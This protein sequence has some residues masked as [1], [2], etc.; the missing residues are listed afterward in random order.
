MKKNLIVLQEGYKECGAASLLSIIR[1]Y[2]GNVSMTR[3]IELTQTNQEGT[4]FYYLKKAAEEIGLEA[5][6]YEVENIQSLKKIKRPFI[7]QF[8]S[9]KC[10]HFVVVFEIKKDKIILMDPAVGE[11]TLSIKEFQS[12]WTS[13]IMI[14]SPAKQ[15][16]FYKEEKY[17]NKIIVE[18]IRKNKAIVLDILLLSIIFMITSFACTTY[19]EF[20]LDYVLDTNL[21]NLLVITLIFSILLLIKSTTSYFRNKLLIYLNQKN[22]CSVLLNTFQ[23]LLLLPY[24]YYKNRTTGEMISRVNDLIYVKNIL[25]KIILTVFLDCIIFICFSIILWL[26]NPRMFLLLVLIILINIIIFNLFRPKLKKNIE[27][28]QINS[29]ILNSNLVE[30]ISGFETIKNMHLEGIINQQIE[31]IYIKALNDN[32]QY[33]DISNLELYIKDMISLIGTLII[34]FLGFVMVMKNQMSIGSFLTFTFLA[35]YVLEPVENILNLNKEYFYAMN[36]IKRANHLFEV[37]SEKFDKKTNFSLKGNIR[38][39]HLTFCYR[40]EQNVLKD[41]TILIPKGEKTIILGNSG[42]GKSTIY[43]LLLKYYPIKRDSIY[44]DEIDLND[45]SIA[46][47]REQIACMSQNEIIFNDTIKNNIIVNRNVSDEEFQKIVKIT[48]VD[49]FVKELFLGYETKLEENGLNLSGGQRQRI[50]LARMLL[51]AN[52]IMLIDEGLNAVDIN[53]ER[54]ILK[55]IFNEYSKNTI[56][57]ISHR[58]DNLDLF[59]HMICFENGKIKEER[60]LPKEKLYD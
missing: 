41:I 50:I 57:V 52:K 13:N 11:K 1:Y 33:E 29:A 2:R 40:E 26:K 20:I 55:N 6:G 17:L 30:I 60:V 34:Q 7:C 53:L 39:H 36:A 22:D 58:I 54:I 38:L 24:N 21:N 46:N 45:Y 48:C 23:K 18:T 28:N 19:F 8:I 31:K 56:I 43:K 15:L 27:L 3:L 25:N 51:K 35:N 12:K 49:E 4:N 14:F 42:S 9:N 37:E 59:D 10:E 5:V 16:T 47:V 32:Y 44:L